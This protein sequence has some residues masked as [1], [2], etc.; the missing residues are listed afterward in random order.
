MYANDVVVAHPA[1]HAVREIGAKVARV[2]RFEDLA[3]RKI[4][5]EC[6]VDQGASA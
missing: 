1:R 3:V 2:Y 4:P 6:A 5:L